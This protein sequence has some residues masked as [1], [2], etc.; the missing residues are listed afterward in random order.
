MLLNSDR[1]IFSRTKPLSEQGAVATRPDPVKSSMTLLSVQNLSVTFNHGRRNVA[2]VSDVSFDIAKGRI[3]GVVGESGSGKSVTSLALT[4]LFP[5]SANAKVRGAVT[6]RG[7]NLIG[8]GERELR[9]IRGAGISYVFQDPLSSL[10]P[11]KRCGEQVAEA[12]R[13]HEPEIPK[14]EVWHRVFDLFVR[15]GLPQAKEVAR[16]YPHELSGGMRQ[17]V[18]IAMAL[19]CKPALLIADEPTT[20]LD[21]VVQK[22]IVALLH[23]VR[24]EF[25][26]S[27]L[28]ITHD[29]G[30]VAS[31]ADDV[32]VMRNG[33]IVENGRSSEV[34]QRPRHAYT[35][36][37]WQATLTLHGP[38][39]VPLESRQGS[40]T[41]AVEE[42]LRV[43]ALS[44]SYSSHR[45]GESRALVLDNISFT[46]RQGETVCVVGESGS[47]K[48]TLARCL[49]GLISPDAGE[50][51]IRG[52][53]V[54][55]GGRAWRAIRRDVQMVFQDPYASLNPRMRVADLVA[56]GLLIN[57]IATSTSDARRRTDEL[58]ELVGLSSSHGA[59]YPHQ[60]SGGQRQRIAIA[61]A[62]AVRPKLLVCDEPVTSLD[63]SVRA[64]I[65]Q[66]LMD[67]QDKE[68]L[69]YVFVT[70]DIALARQI[71]DQVLVMSRGRVVE[72]G[73]ALDVIDHPKH[74]YT[75]ALRAAVPDPESALTS[76][77]RIRAK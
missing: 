40:S 20:A 21:V 23:D 51:S 30:L 38:S 64:Q 58:L 59:R 57:K 16:K 67:I 66:L 22:Q 65:V 6:F 71:G 37:L 29:L 11:V 74:E 69:T 10:N 50:I 70:H 75:R 1:Q 36:Q 62:L 42:M 19:A 41:S 48:S 33:Q 3:V 34:C 56:E 2:A 26:T 46:A 18:M 44:H 32:L 54:A 63:V 24:S 61:R 12:I 52:L 72:S 28:F 7:A 73:A 25:G 76:S 45:R 27:I 39:R 47:G 4:K 68:R 31:I 55:Q 8:L 43:N 15:L 60:F 53:Q 14:D 9:S 77:Q 35:K 17:R 5:K 49:V 13:I